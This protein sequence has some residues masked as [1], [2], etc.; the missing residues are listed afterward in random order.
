[1]NALTFLYDKALYWASH[2]RAT[3]YLALLS[4]AESSFFPVPP[5]VMLAPMALAKPQKA[6]NYALI[7]TLA[8]VLGGL[9]GYV[10]GYFAFAS[11]IE[12][13]LQVCGY[14]V[15][16]QK[17][18]LW[19]QL[20]GFAVIFLAGFSPIPY[21]LF[22]I[23]AGVLQF[24]ILLFL[25]ASII[26]RSA[27]FF[28]VSAIIYKGGSRMETSIRKCID[29]LGWLIVIITISIGAVLML[30]SCNTTQPPAKVV[31]LPSPKTWQAS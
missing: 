12:P 11:I 21:K 3:R 10:L 23:G 17:V 24:N 29:K 2:P 25:M 16:Y 14:Q 9:L 31:R 19:F 20:Y 5:D 26:G 8:S 4:F 30:T 15:T 7:A 1:M 18:L 22:T 6:Y 27:R 28:L 13:F